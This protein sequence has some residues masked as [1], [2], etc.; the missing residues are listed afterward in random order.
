MKKAVPAVGTFAG[1]CVSAMVQQGPPILSLK[2]QLPCSTNQ[3]G[4]QFEEVF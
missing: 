1:I 2:V 3:N 4:K